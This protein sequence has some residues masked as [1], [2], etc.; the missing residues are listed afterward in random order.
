M[1]EEAEVVVEE[2][3]EEDCLS[4]SE[5]SEECRLVSLRFVEIVD[6]NLDQTLRFVF[7]SSFYSAFSFYCFRR[8]T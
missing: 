7:L 2:A 8:Q 6:S 3:V 5:E 4:T 1:Q